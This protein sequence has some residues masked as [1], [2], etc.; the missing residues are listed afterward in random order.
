M[1]NLQHKCDDRLEA[2]RTPFWSTLEQGDDLWIVDVFEFPRY[3]DH[4]VVYHDS[5]K[6]G[7]Y[8]EQCL[9]FLQELLRLDGNICFHGGCED[10][11][12]E[13]M[14]GSTRGGE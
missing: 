9:A 6:D 4:K 5:V 10:K 11:E 1:N 12:D 2:S 3:T 14:D 8:Y 13:R 7:Q